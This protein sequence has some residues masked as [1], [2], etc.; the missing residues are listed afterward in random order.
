[1]NIRNGI[2]NISQ[3]F[4]QDD[5]AVW[6]DGS[7]ATLGE[8]WSGEASHKSDD[9]EIIRENDSARLKEALGLT[10]DEFL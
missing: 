2:A 9:Y 5:V 4:T 3:T 10:D 8:V 6:P 1:M 7:W